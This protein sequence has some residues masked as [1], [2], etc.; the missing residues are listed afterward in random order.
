MNRTLSASL[1]GSEAFGGA[2]NENESTA[3]FASG[4]W[5]EAAT[6]LVSPAGNAKADVMSFALASRDVNAR[7]FQFVAMNF[8]ID[9]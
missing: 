3:V 1:V 4:A 8:R 2:P 9:V 5:R 6:W 7:R